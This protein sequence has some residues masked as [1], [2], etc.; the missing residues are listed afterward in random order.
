[1]TTTYTPGPWHLD[2][3]NAPGQVLVRGEI[4]PPIASL[5]PHGWGQDYMANAH[6]IATAPELLEDLEDLASAI[7]WM[8]H[9]RKGIDWGEDIPYIVRRSLETIRKAKGERV[10]RD[11]SI[12]GG[13]S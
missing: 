9:N 3:T 1:M 8:L 6:L 4:P 13:E 11:D 5:L 12:I 2:L 10:E 7:N